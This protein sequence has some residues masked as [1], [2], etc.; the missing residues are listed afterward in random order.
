[1]KRTLTPAERLIVA[2]D[3]KPTDTRPYISL[4]GKSIKWRN[5]VKVQVLALADSLKD[6][7]V[8]LKVNSALW[9]CGYGLIDEIH[10]R[11]LRVFADLKLFDIRGW[12]SDFE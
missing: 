6:T 3:F 11:G 8:Y 9:A 12:S 4:D 2:A 7:G 1:M 5:E 10:S